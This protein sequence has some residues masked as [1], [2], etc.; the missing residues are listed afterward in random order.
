[1]NKKR[2]SLWGEFLKTGRIEDYLKYRVSVK[3]AKNEDMEIALLDYEDAQGIEEDR[4]N[5]P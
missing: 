4:G 1:M 2:D 5:R 3:T